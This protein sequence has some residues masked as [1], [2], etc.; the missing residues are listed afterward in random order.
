A[1]L[2]YQWKI[3]GLTSKYILKKSLKGFLPNNILNRKKMGFGVPIGKWFRGELKNYLTETL[4]AQ[5]SIQ[6]GY[7][8]KESIERLLT[9]HFSGRVSHTYRLWSLL[10]L[11]VWHQIFIDKSIKF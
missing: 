10:V 8:R 3:K 4:L 6:R 7:F 2:P 11:E 5:K 9:E 1:T